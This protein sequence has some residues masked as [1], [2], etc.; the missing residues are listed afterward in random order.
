VAGGAGVTDPSTRTASAEQVEAELLDRARFA[1]SVQQQ[2]K[3]V[4]AEK[5]SREILAVDP[6][7]FHAT[8]LLGVVAAH[9]NRFDYS[10][11][12]LPATGPMSSPASNAR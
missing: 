5:I 3:L 2:G 8:D 6:D 7:H 9:P 10:V 12:P 4:E 1:C 11:G